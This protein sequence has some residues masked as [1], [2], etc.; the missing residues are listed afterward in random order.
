MPTDILILAGVE[1]DSYSTPQRMMGGGNQAMVVHKL[2]GGDRTIDTLGP[3]E[4]DT[5]DH[6]H[7]D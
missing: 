5:G 1:F 6:D 7:T 4:A 3:D 2:P